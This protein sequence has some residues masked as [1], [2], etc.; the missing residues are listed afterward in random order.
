[1]SDVLWMELPSPY[2]SKKL[3]ETL[4]GFLNAMVPVPV[5]KEEGIFVRIWEEGVGR[6]MRL[7]RCNGHR[8]CF[9][10]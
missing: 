7:K 8:C 3:S 6:F 9:I 10:R 1:M 4:E 2:N 5:S